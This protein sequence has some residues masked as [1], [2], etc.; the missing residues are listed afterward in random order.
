M[1]DN[2][3]KMKC[4]KIKQS[5]QRMAV[6]DHHHMGSHSVTC[7]PAKVTFQPLPPAKVVTRFNDPK[8]CNAK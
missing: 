8:K 7:H 2:R 4:N 5:K 3:V 6:R 1:G